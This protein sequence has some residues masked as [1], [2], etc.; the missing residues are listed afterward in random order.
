VGLLVLSTLIHLLPTQLD[1][2]LQAAIAAANDL[3]DE[4][5]RGLFNDLLAGKPPDPIAAQAHLYLGVLDYNALDK[6]HGDEELSRALELD[7]TLETPPKT[8]PKIA[9]AFEELRRKLVQK[10][11]A[12]A[13]A[14]S[15]SQ[16]FLAVDQEA[17]GPR[18][19]PW[20]LGAGAIAAG[21]VSVWGWVEVANFEGLKGPTPVTPAQAKSAQAAAQWGQPVGIVA[22][23]AAAGLIAGTVFTW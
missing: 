13:P 22:A 17:P 16:A 19:W 2:K 9:L 21:A 10:L 6:L 12:A 11:R 7:P 4:R 8:S 14:P 3:D 15:S 18:V 23:I 1:A 20:V 5:A